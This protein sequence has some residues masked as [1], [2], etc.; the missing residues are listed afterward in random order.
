MKKAIVTLSVIML[1]AMSAFAQSGDETIRYNTQKLN[2]GW[3][4]DLA[5][6]YS[7]FASNGSAYRDI[8]TYYGGLNNKHAKSLFGLS[9]KIGR[10]VSPSAAVR[11][12]YDWHPSYNADS[13]FNFKSLHVDF[14]ESPLDLFLGYNPKR[15]WTPWVY[16]GFGLLAC[17]KFPNGQTNKGNYRFLIH[18]NSNLEFGLH[19][20]IMNNFRINNSLDFHIDFTSV[21]TKWSFDSDEWG[22]G[23][24]FHRAHYELTGMAGLMWYIGGRGFDVAETA[25][26]YVTDCSEEESIIEELMEELERC[27]ANN[28]VEV[29]EEG[30][31]V[32]PQPCDTIVKFVEGESI[33][34]PFSI[35]FNKGSYELR[36]GRDRVNLEEFAKAAKAN[37]YKV[38]LR[39]TCDSATASSSFNQTLAENRCNKVKQELVRLGVPENTITINPVGGVRELTPAE[40]DRRVLIQLSK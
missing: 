40:Y 5:G 2:Q 4:I 36:D 28:E 16:G 12:G 35:F 13:Y 21:I 1:T 38:I 29:D 34:Y 9:F 33:S 39:G 27:R 14:M 10:R 6:T 11:I 37:G 26:Y 25:E 18:W 15:F 8:T 17:D 32:E 19:T 24:L 3:F 31:V 22:G 23:T 30:N 7:F 20:G